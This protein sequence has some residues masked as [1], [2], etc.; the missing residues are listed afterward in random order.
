MVIIRVLGGR[1]SKSGKLTILTVLKLRLQ[2]ILA[3][4]LHAAG[5]PYEYAFPQGRQKDYNTQ[6]PCDVMSL[7]I[8]KRD[9]H[10]CMANVPASDVDLVTMR[11]RQ[12]F[13]SSLADK[14]QAEVVRQRDIRKVKGLPNDIEVIGADD[15]YLVSL[16]H[17]LR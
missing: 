10:C 13:V 16:I 12:S 1:V 9:P 2:L 6:R 4:R 8:L 11:E 7:W 14:R 3:A 17:Q 5:I 15:V